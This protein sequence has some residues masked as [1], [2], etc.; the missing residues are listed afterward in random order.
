VHRLRVALFAAAFVAVA[1]L[2]TCAIYDPS[3]L[4]PAPID[5]ST[6][7]GADVALDAGADVVTDPCQHTS[8]PLPPTT[9]DGT[10]D[11]DFVLAVSYL[12][13]LPQ[14]T[15]NVAHPHVPVGFDLDHTCT[16]P[17]PETCVPRATT[18][19]CDGDGGADNSAGAVFQTFA[20]LD[21]NFSDDGINQ[22][23]GSGAYTLLLRVKSYNGGQNDKQVTFIVYSSHGTNGVQDGGR[24]QPLHDGTDVWTIDPTSLL[25]GVAVDGGA[26]CE[27]NDNVCV[28]FFADTQAYVSNGTLVAHLDFPIIVGAGNAQLLVTLTSC[29]IAAPI[30]FDGKSYRLD[31]AQLGGRWG[32]G[33]LL[34]A[35][36]TAT[37]PLGPG[38]LCGDSGAYQN[39]KQRICA[40][41]DITTNAAR[42]NSGQRCDALSVAIAFSAS[43]A[44]LGPIFQNPP[45]GAP[46]G[47]DYQDDC[48]DAQ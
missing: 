48:P 11:V 47:V 23:L 31:E 45:G 41:A 28:P 22:G 4:L 42:D 14:G 16:C 13:L 26:T 21:S 20:L 40:A 17:A 2:S 43:A 24:T 15:A 39:I 36:Q 25:G 1:A 10:G 38:H 30:V 18:Q 9:E 44:H 5:A 37:D 35:L 27:G 29:E 46:C 7:A 3:L 12:R 34:T 19:H 32:T 8:P 6:D 33:G